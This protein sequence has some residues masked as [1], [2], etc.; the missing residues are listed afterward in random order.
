MTKFRNLKPY[1]L[2][3][4]MQQRVA[5]ARFLAN[6]PDVLLMDEPFSVLDAYSRIQL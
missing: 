5:I 3:G 2:S 4:G 6:N 1:E